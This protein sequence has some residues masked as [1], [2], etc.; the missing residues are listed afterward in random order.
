MHVAKAILDLRDPSGLPALIDVL[1]KGE[2]RIPREEAAKLRKERTG[3]KATDVAALRRWWLER[4][5]KLKWRAE[6]KRFE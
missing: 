6:T 4:G 3:Q 5:T 1:E 2:A